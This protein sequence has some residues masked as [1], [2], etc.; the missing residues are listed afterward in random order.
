M[1]ALVGAPDRARPHLHGRRQRLL[2]HRERSRTTASSRA[3]TSRAS[4][5]ARASTPTGTTR[6]TRATSCC[7][8]RRPTSRSGRSGTRPS[9]AAGPGWH[10]EC[11]AMS[12]KYLGETF[13]LHCGGV[14]LI[15][16][17]HENEIA[18]STCGTGK[19]FVR[20]WMHVEH[21]LVDE[22]DDVEEQ[23]QR[24]HDPR[25]SL[26][27]GHRPDAVRYLLSSAHYRKTAQL[28]LGG[29]AARRRRRSSA[30]TASRGGWP[31]S[32]ARGR[33]RRRSRRRCAASA[34]EAFDAALCDDL[35]TPEALAAVHGLVSEGNALLAGGSR[36]ARGRRRGCGRSSSRWT[37]CSRVL[38]PPTRTASR[39]R[40]RRSSTSA[41]RR[42]R[43]ASSRAPTSCARELEALG[44]RPRGHAE[45]HAVAPA[46]GLTRA[47][48]GPGRRR[49]GPGLPLPG[50]AR[51]SRSWRATSAA[52]RARWTSWPSGTATSRCSSR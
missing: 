52:A 12:M 39:P 35:N 27:R 3:S 5:P 7:G 21:L 14:D 42:A 17:H 23:G 1:V 46:E 6:R 47:A 26:E 2:P 20:H 36:D 48:S 13:D 15:F 45:G 16:P 32:T 50:A 28:H 37:A 24:L 11:S 10:I 30:S 31:R 41:R 34:D 4:R 18:Q 29:P 19:P 25:A 44:H 49:R 38:L 9:A 8:R 22:R 40:S 33:R 51:L 43:R